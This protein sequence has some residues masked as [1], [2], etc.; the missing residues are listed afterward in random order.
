MEE[1]CVCFLNSWGWICKNFLQFKLFWSHS[2]MCAQNQNESGASPKQM[3]KGSLL[4]THIDKW[5]L[6]AK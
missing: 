3:L 5:N 1:R 4:N 2:L 6:K